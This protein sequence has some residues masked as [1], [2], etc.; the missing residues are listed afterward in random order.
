MK[1]LKW[2]ERESRRSRDRGKGLGSHT[3]QGPGGRDED[4]G[5][6]LSEMGVVAAVMLSAKYF[7]SFP[8]DLRIGLLFFVPLKL[9]VAMCLAQSTEWEQRWCGHFE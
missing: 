6:F 2:K 1:Q 9:C 5:Y 3:T 4:L 7:L 8:S